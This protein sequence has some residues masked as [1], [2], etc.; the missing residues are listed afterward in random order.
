MKNPQSRIAYLDVFPKEAT[1]G[2]QLNWQDTA[3]EYLRVVFDPTLT[4]PELPLCSVFDGETAAGY[5]GKMFSIPSYVGSE[6]K[7]MPSE[8]LTCLGSSLCACLSPNR[9]KYDAFI[10]MTKAYF[11]K[12]GQHGVVTNS[13]HLQP[14]D[15]GNS[16]WY[17][18]FP[19]ILYVL[20]TSFCKE[21]SEFQ[22]QVKEIADS[23]C[24]VADKM[25][26][27]WEH[28]GYSLREE[29]PRDT[30]RWFESDA[31]QGIAY[32]AYIAYIRTGEGKYLRCAKECLDEAAAFDYNPYYEILGSYAPYTAAR[33]EAETGREGHLSAMLQTVFARTTGTRTGWG[34]IDEQWGDYDAY[35]L[36]GSTTDTQ[37]YAFAMNT[38]ATAAALA[39]T[40]RYAPW[41]AREMARYLM[42]VK[43]NSALFFPNGLP[44]NMQA[45]SGWVRETG[46][47][48][49]SYEG[50]RK[51][52]ATIPYGTGDTRLDMNPYGAWGSGLMAALF[53]ANDNPR[54]FVGDIRAIEGDRPHNL[55]TYL[56]YN[57]TG[58]AQ[59]VTLP[60]GAGHKGYDLCQNAAVP[61]E[62]GAYILAPDQVM[63]LC[64]IPA[65]AILT[66]KAG[67]T[68]ADDTLIDYFADGWTEKVF[69]PDVHVDYIRGAKMTA[70]SRQSLM[71]GPENAATSDWHDAWLSIDNPL[72]EWL[73][74]ELCNKV[75]CTRINIIWY[76]AQNRDCAASRFTLEASLD[77][78][79]WQLLHEAKENNRK[80]VSIPLP[81]VPLRFIRITCLDKVNRRLPYGITDVQVFGNRR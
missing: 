31:V 18:I 62:K 5:K 52:G 47:C 58:E 7:P 57:P 78:V 67:K 45:Q 15:T 50:V 13:V 69:V 77:G 70:S 35:G 55:P 64:L 71:Y 40:V 66:T 42:H 53:P 76:S 61:S 59:A 23:W 1:T 29:A 44:D 75:D 12:V 14:G 3:A 21:D 56:L 34:I 36:S 10:Q 38:Y 19:S 4:G 26:G 27:D 60:V 2:V 25:R 51:N 80:F 68:Y 17:D 24:H 16:F 81:G 11:S 20:I 28:T 9:E 63:V 72:T 65:E 32:I 46:I 37:G 49:I 54:V 33:M 22:A 39:P 43:R 73:T 30:L 41:H 48:A 6:A 74:A 8:G 79:H